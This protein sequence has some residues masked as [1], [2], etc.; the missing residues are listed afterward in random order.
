MVLN[1]EE[2]WTYSEGM[3]PRDYFAAAAMAALI[4]LETEYENRSCSGTSREAYEYADA[5]LAA[6][7]VPHE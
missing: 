7:E 2:Q 4:P 3:S 1:S 5:M 6:R